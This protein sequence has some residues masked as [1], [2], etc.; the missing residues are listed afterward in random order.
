MQCGCPKC[1]TLMGK[2]ERGLDSTCVCPKCGFQCDICVGKKTDADP[3]MK[4]HTKQ[5]EWER[6]AQARGLL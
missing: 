1:G 5:E 3:K 2:A 6:L 4:K